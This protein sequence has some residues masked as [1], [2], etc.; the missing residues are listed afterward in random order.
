MKSQNVCCEAHYFQYY[1]GLFPQNIFWHIVA[2]KSQ[3]QIIKLTLAE[4]H[5]AASVLRSWCCECWLT[6]TLSWLTEIL[7]KNKAIINAVTF[8]Y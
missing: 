4:F 6:V 2:G 8:F 3:V 7:E 1:T 5:L